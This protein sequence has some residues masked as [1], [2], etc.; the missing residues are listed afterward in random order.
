MRLLVV[1]SGKIA[2]DLLHHAAALGHEVRIASPRNE[3]LEALVAARSK[4]VRRLER[5]GDMTVGQR[6]V[7]S[8]LD[9]AAGVE[10]T[11]VVEA[12]I[13]DRCAKSKVADRVEGALG[14]GA[15]LASVS[16]SLLP[17]EIHPAAVGLHVFYPMALTG[18]VE[19]VLPAPQGALAD[20]ARSLCS[21]LRLQA[22]EQGEGEAFAINRMLLPWQWEALRAVTLGID[23]QVVDAAS[24][25]PWQGRGALFL[26]DSVGLSVIHA[27]VKTYLS[28][29]P[30]IEA[31]ELAPLERGLAELGQRGSLDPGGL[32][33]GGPLPWTVNGHD[34]EPELSERLSLSLVNGA[35]QAV[36]RG[37]ISLAELNQA[38]EAALGACRS[39]EEALWRLGGPRTVHDS[40]TA[41]HKHTG[42]AYFAPA[43][44]LGSLVL[45]EPCRV[46]RGP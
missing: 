32:L 31:D 19:L 14:K 42:L 12:T 3:R 37:G 25:G 4:L 30:A 24:G 1:G 44:C 13:E 27:A 46:G 7:V 11:A 34:L 40:L 2:L 10:L 33:R 6:V 41:L 20:R 5:A 39:F 8:T 9:E 17:S 23:P 38:F 45:G 21:D 28:R 22:I 29:L 15:L 35:L 36:D 26:M 43:R 16:S 18:L